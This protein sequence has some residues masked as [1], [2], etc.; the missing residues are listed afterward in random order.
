MRLVIRAGT[1]DLDIASTR[2]GSDDAAGNN[3]LVVECNF[4]LLNFLLAPFVELRPADLPERF[5]V[6]EGCRE[7]VEIAAAVGLCSLPE[8]RDILRGD[9]IVI[10]ARWNDRAGTICRGAVW[11]VRFVVRRLIAA[12]NSKK[13]QGVDLAIDTVEGRPGCNVAI[14]GPI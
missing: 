11:V 13:W 14:A 6:R 4:A 7:C 12:V 9:D 2:D 5:R 10:K 1:R 8:R 3:K